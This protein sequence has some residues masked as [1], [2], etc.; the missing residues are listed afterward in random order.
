MAPQPVTVTRQTGLSIYRQLLRQ[1]SYLP[2]A[3]RP[4]IQTSI[5]T[6][7]HQHRKYDP[8]AQQHWKRARR[9]LGM[10]IAANNG[11]GSCMEN[12]IAKAFGRAGIRRRQL[13]SEFVVPQGVNDSKALEA[14]T[15]GEGGEAAGD[16]AETEKQKRPS[17]NPK[18]RFFLKW[19]QPKLL[20]L[21]STQRQH[22]KR[23]GPIGH[24]LGD[25]VK[26]LNPDIEVPEKNIWG[27]APVDAVVNA[28][29]ARWWRRS[30]DKMQPPLGKGEWELLGRLSHGAQESGEWQIPPRRPRAVGSGDG[31]GDGG[32]ALE[33]LE[34]KE[35]KATA[36]MRYASS[37]A[38]A[39]ERKHARQQAARSGEQD[40]GPYGHGNARQGRGLSPRWFRRAYQ[41][42]WLVTPKMEQDPRTLQYKFT[43][44]E[45]T[46]IREATPQQLSIFDGVDSKGQPLR[47]KT[48]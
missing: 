35:S 48:E 31:D 27:D 24:L 32:A 16:K 21:L 28:K 26:T 8:R 11:N 33:R 15:S 47:K 13:M 39:V 30:A 34:G 18:N 3:V 9:T 45:G 7:F 12:L 46:G 25:S 40:P 6:R 37:T 43:F 36:L 23:G 4:A 5:Q 41:R 2:P 44:G 38:A 14:L 17:G 29:R 1:C 22:R 42:A 20:R 10:L 19:D